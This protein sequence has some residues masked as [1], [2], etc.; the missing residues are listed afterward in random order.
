VKRKCAEC[1]PCPHGKRKD[2]CTT[3]RSLRSTRR[4]TPS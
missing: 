3:C 1:N 4:E 2:H